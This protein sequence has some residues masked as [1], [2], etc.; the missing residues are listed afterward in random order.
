MDCCMSSDA[1]AFHSRLRKPRSAVAGKADDALDKVG[2]G[3]HGVVEDDNFAAVNNRGGEDGWSFVEA[4]G[5]L[6]YE[7]EVAD[8]EGGFHGAGWDAEGLNG[9]G[10]DEDGDDDDVEERLNGGE[11]AMLVV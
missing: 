4:E 9:E 5:V 8:E 11:Q 1:S 3:V 10:K 7:K 6:V 2:I